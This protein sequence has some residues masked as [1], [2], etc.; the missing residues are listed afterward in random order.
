MDLLEGKTAVVV[1][2]GRGIGQAS[3]RAFA[4]HG[5]TVCVVDVDESEAR[6]TAEELPDSANAIALAC[7]VA[8]VAEV[9]TVIS[10][11]LDHFGKVDILLNTAG[12]VR[13][14][15]LHKMTDEEWDSVMNVH[16][17]GTFNFVRSVY[18][19]MRERER[20]RIINV[21][22]AAGLIGTIGQVNY[23]A[24]KAAIM[25]ITKSTALEMAKFNVTA[26][27][28]SPGPTAT[29]MTETL[30]TDPRF[31]EKYLERIPLRR[32]AQPEDI[33]DAAVFLASDLS[34]FVTGQVLQVDGGF[35]MR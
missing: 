7:D 25:A 32:W 31:S 18:A 6:S 1:G 33:A 29:R 4:Q 22:S 10:K 12:N 35:L 13:A 24:A 3:A 17:R 21:T 2:A 20:G 8:Q 14:A 16:A 19:H 30:R 27:A 11:A 5:A 9:R 26:N 15:M 34:R 23:A 28:L